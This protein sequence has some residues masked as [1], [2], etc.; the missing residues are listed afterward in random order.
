MDIGLL[1]TLVTVASPAYLREH[2]RPTTLDEFLA[3]RYVAY[4]RDLA[5]HR[6]W[7]RASFGGRARAE[8]RIACFVASLPEMQ[9]LAEA[10]VGVAILPDYLVEAA[11]AER[12]LE[13]LRPAGARRSARNPI[14]LAWRAAA[15]E[16]AR[17]RALRDALTGEC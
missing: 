14:Y 1:E 17:L 11:I 10:G 3:H 9:A 7:W 16:S 4:D 8:V 13:P 12:R 5:M 6:P 15:L 2:G